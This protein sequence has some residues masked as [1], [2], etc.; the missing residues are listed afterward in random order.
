MQWKIEQ[1]VFVMEKTIKIK[2]IK[3]NVSTN[4]SASSVY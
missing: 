4:S 3:V 2:L 1:S